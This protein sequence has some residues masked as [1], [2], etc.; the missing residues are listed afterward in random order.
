MDYPDERKIHKNLVPYT[1][2]ILI[3]LSLYIS[4]FFINVNNLIFT[5]IFFSSFFFILG[6]IDDIYNLKPIIKLFFQI[7]IISL[8]LIQ[9]NVQGYWII[10]FNSFFINF[11]INLFWLTL[12]VNAINLIDGVDGVAITLSIIAFSCFAI[13]ES[14]KDKT[15]YLFL[16]IIIGSLIGLLKYNLPDAK[17]F[18]GD[19]GSLTLGFLLGALSMFISSKT[20]LTYSIFIP[21]TT[22][23]I[24]IID[25]FMVSLKRVKQKKSIFSA[26]KNHIHHELLSL[27]F[28]KRQVLMILSLTTSFFSILSLYFPKIKILIIFTIIILLINIFL[29][30][31]KITNLFNFKFLIKKYNRIGR[32]I[33]KKIINPNYSGNFK[34]NILSIIIILISVLL[35]NINL[36]INYKFFIQYLLFFIIFV[37]NNFFDF[38]DD[39]TKI[40]SNFTIFWYYLFISYSIF[41]LN[42]EFHYFFIFILLILNF[43]KIIIEKRFELFL[44]NPTEIILIHLLVIFLFNHLINFKIIILAFLLYNLSKN[45]VIKNTKEYKI[46]YPMFLALSLLIPLIKMIKEMI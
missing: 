43:V 5:L 37:A 17:I 27:G 38:Q 42:K 9:K 18:L 25:V 32:L 22:I 41:S 23:L 14:P 29:I 36:T 4:L 2:G 1:G 46:F 10:F 40:F 30:I 31:I 21:I 34:F 33:I 24:P 13:I 12:I 15:L 44:Y 45:F 8:F 28:S 35:V 11:F 39:T 19:N 16:F 3:V 26:D 7:L 20:L 6:L